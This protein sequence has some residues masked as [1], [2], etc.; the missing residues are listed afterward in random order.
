MLIISH[1]L[2]FRSGP[3]NLTSMQEAWDAL[4]SI[5]PTAITTGQRCRDAEMRSQVS[6][7]ADSLL[8]SPVS[9]VSMVVTNDHHDHPILLD[10]DST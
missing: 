2:S 7:A 5:P 6:V 4:A 8:T 9:P 3:C 1:L 10:G